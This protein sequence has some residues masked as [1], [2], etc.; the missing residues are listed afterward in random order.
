MPLTGGPVRQIVK[1]VRSGGEYTSASQGIY[2][3][4]CGT[5]PHAEVHLLHPDGRDEVLGALEKY[6]GGT[7]ASPSRRMESRFC[8]E[9]TV[10]DGSDLMLIENFK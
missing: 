9:S 2:Y 7:S 5:D 1:C 8:T 3:V 4:A 10:S 6:P